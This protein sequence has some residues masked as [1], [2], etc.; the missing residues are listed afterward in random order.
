MPHAPSSPA[1]FSPDEVAASLLPVSQ[2]RSRC[3]QKYEYS[4]ALSELTAEQT[5]LVE[6]RNYTALVNLLARK[7]TLVDAL[8][9]VSQTEP[10]L[11]IAWRQHRHLLSPA[12]RQECETWLAQA[13]TILAHLIATEHACSTQVEQDHQQTR[14]QLATASQALNVHLAYEETFTGQQFDANR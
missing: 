11:P 13:E 12:V 4:R 2:L 1:R 8:L 6:E 14:Q 9:Q 7:Q 5:Q 10:P 3:Q